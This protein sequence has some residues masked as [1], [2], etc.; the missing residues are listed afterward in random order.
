MDRDNQPNGNR[1]KKTHASTFKFAQAV[2]PTNILEFHE[3]HEFPENTKKTTH[4]KHRKTQSAENAKNA[5]TKNTEN[6]E[7]AETAE[8][9]ENAENLENATKRRKRKQTKTLKT[10]K[11]RKTRKRTKRRKR[12]QRKKRKRTNRINKCLLNRNHLARCGWEKRKE[13]PKRTQL[14]RKQHRQKIIPL[15]RSIYTWTILQWRQTHKPTHRDK[16]RHQHI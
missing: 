2:P 4:T 13:V 9:A 1:K 14:F 10:Q 5:K 11:I 12:K 6:T 15:G 16:Q 3:F 8:N 7:N